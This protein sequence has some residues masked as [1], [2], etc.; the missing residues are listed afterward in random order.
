MVD[1]VMVVVVLGRLGHGRVMVVEAVD[2]SVMVVEAVDR[3]SRWRW[4]LTEWVWVDA[5]A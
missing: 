5:L 3:V 4:C 2:K 1:R